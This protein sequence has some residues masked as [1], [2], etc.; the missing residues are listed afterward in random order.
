MTSNGAGDQAGATGVDL[1]ALQNWVH[2]AKLGS[3]PLTDV[4]GI[5]GGTQNIMLRFSCDNR[6]FVLRRGPAHLR[7]TTNDN[8]RR[9][10]RLLTALADTPVPHAKL[11]HACLD[12]TIL[13]GSVFYLMEPIDGFNAAVEL[14]EPHASTPSIR[15]QMGLSAVEALAELSMVD[16][17]AVQ[18]GDFGR[19][20]GFLDRQV[21]RWLRE[22]DT[23]AHSNGYP[24]HGFPVEKVAGW[25]SRNQPTSGPVGIMHG[26]YHLANVMFGYGS[27]HVAAIVDWEMATIGDPMLDLGWL[28]ATWPEPGQ[29]HDVIGSELARA[30]ALPPAH[31]L[32]RIY[33]ERTGYD[34]SAADWYAVLACFKLG[35][36]LEGTYARA[37]AGL[38]PADVGHRLHHTA[39]ALFAR[40]LTLTN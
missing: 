28:L 9:E 26:D 13:G 35:I 31:E 2:D 32:V 36:L 29:A 21:P 37:C 7:S 30:G 19:P 15:H 4:R 40:A 11:I 5:G 1:V 39:E 12:E 3:G 23:Y 20:E 8:L 18:L 14:P 17:T 27:P 38:A 10:I 25:L 24:G 16:Y 33:G 22:L 34:V 6:E